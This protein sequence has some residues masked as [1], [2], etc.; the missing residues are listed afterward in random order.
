MV[1]VVL[2]DHYLRLTAISELSKRQDALKTA[3]AG[4]RAIRKGKKNEGDPKLEVT[5]GDD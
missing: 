3:I 1:R 4:G 5:R 2:A